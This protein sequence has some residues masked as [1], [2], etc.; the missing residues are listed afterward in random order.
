L[1]KGANTMNAKRIGKWVLVLFLLA[2]LPGM[3]VALA[4]GQEPVGKAPLPAVTEMGESAA[5]SAVRSEVESNN[6]M[7]LADA[8]N[9]NDVMTGKIGS[10]GDIDYFK[11][12]VPM[13]K[14]SAGVGI[15][16]LIDIDA[17]S[18][19]SNLDAVICLLDGSGEELGCD[20]DSDTFDS[21]YY[22]NLYRENDFPD[23]I[24]NGWYYVTVR[25]FGNA[26]GGNDHFYNLIV[27][28]PILLSAAAANL[29]TG[30]VAG[31]PFQA[32]D[33]LA[34]SH[35]GNNQEKWV[36]FF[37]A[38]DVGITKNIWNIGAEGGAS[39]LFLGFMANQSLAK[40]GGG[41][42]IIATPFDLVKFVVADSHDGAGYGSQGYGPS[43]SGQGF[44][45]YLQ[46]QNQ[47]LTLASEKIDAFD[48]WQ[49]GYGDS[50]AG[51]PISTVGAASVTGAG[52]VILRAADEDVM[53]N[54]FS[55]WKMYFD[56]ST[57]A[58]MTVEDVYAMAYDDT[59]ERLYLTILATG[60]VLG[61][62]VTQKDV[63]A[64]SYPNRTWYGYVFRGTQHGWNYNIDAVEYSGYGGW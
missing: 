62:A 9:I 46:G 43:T 42:N 52:G 11:F 18:I 56:G 4:Q 26:H 63:F 12:Q 58:G 24:Y 32:P 23:A 5:P 54:G 53:C 30:N 13:Q 33:I 29:G 44:Y 25:D 51:H 45:R 64:L 57:V 31:I 47:Q 39:N 41:T 49:Y 36:M 19:S 7:G 14:Y 61:H 27:S 8:M 6:T 15:E 59:H 40:Y 38:S 35:V 37:D 22:R 2:A 50:C 48:G 17:Q 28:S 21:L 34:H 20:D 16:I 1:E 60:N 3:T 55:P 10:V